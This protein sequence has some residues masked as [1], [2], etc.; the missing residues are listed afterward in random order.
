[1]QIGTILSGVGVPTTI[2]T[3]FVPQYLMYVGATQ[4]QSLKVTVFGDG[5]TCDLD[6]AGLNLL[7]SQRLIGS[8]LNTYIIPIADG[9]VPGKNVEIIAVNGVAANIAIFG[10]NMKYGSKYIQSL[11]QTVLASSGANFANF[12]F[13]SLANSGAADL[14]NITY[15]DGMTQKVDVQNELPAIAS[16]Y[17]NLVNNSNYIIDNWQ[18]NV[19]NVQYTPVATQLVHLVRVVQVGPLLQNV[20]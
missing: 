3:T 18:G 16:M 19:R 6:T 5:I 20:Q 8:K 10:I 1:M 13:L 11:R 2:N 4:L 9:L 17:Q 12:S 15:R 7:G 14:L